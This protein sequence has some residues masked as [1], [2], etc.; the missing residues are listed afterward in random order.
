MMQRASRPWQSWQRARLHNF[1]YRTYRPAE[2]SAGLLRGQRCSGLKRERRSMLIFFD[3][4]GTLIGEETHIMPESAK[5]AI[6]R[7]RENGHI[8]MI[9]TGRS[10]KLVGP[11]I[12]GLVE[13]DG[14]VMGCGTMITY[15]GETLLHKTFLEEEARR[16]I[17]GLQRYRIDAVL[18]GSENNFCDS[19]DRIFTETFRQFIHRFD[20]LQYEGYEKAPGH[21]DKFYAYADSAEKMNAFRREFEAL[22]DFVDR[23]GGYFEITPKGCSKASAMRFVSEKLGIPMSRTVAVGD[24]SNDIP[25]LACAGIGIAMGNASEEVKEFADFVTASVEEDGIRKALSRLGVL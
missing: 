15:R 16:I 20:R 12:T 7:A 18:E 21:F 25:M 17:D 5:G 8:C 1:R 10:K 2:K 14:F 19:D 9:N 24:S 3:I 13:F 4:D 22:L 23:R 6:R 11:D